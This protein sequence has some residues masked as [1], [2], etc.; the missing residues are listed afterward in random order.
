MRFKEGNAGRPKGA[1]NKVTND[2]KLKFETLLN[3]NLTTLQSDIDKMQPR[4]RVH[5]ILELAK[6]VIPTLRATDIDLTTN[7][8]NFKIITLNMPDIGNRTTKNIT[9]KKP[10][11]KTKE[12]E[13][14]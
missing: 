2:I 11:I 13:K 12:D 7:E 9:F 3:D 5:Y 6:Y 1:K 14:D 10:I 8:D 4:W